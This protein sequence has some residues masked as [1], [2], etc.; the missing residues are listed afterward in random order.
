MRDK[1]FIWAAMNKPQQ[2]TLVRDVE[3]ALVPVGQKV[4]LKKGQTVTIVQAHAGTC[5]VAVDG[6]LFWI[7]CKDADA[8]GLSPAENPCA[9]IHHKLTQEEVEQLVW[10]QLKNCYDPEIP[11]NIVD[12]GLVY[13]CKLT[14]GECPD[15][16]NVHIKMTLTA[17]GCGMGPW[18]ANDVREKVL[19]VPQVHDVT[20][21]LVW[22]P[23]WSQDRLSDAAKLQLG[24]L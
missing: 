6:N 3:A 15:T 2:V 1:Y 12:L 8:L 22:D 13:E 10:K 11:I 24:L 17:P 4:T 7:D 16:Y 18:I 9:Q 23:P 5:T 14:P 19:Q 20:V 21:D